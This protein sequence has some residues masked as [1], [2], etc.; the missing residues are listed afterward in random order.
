[1]TWSKE[2]DF[3]FGSVPGNVASSIVNPPF[4]GGGAELLVVFGCIDVSNSCTGAHFSAHAN[5]TTS[6]FNTITS[7]ATNG[8]TIFCMLATWNGPAQ[9][10][11][12]GVV[13]DGGNSGTNG[14]KLATAIFTGYNPS[15]LTTGTSSQF[16]TATSGTASATLVGINPGDLV[17]AMQDNSGNVVFTPGAGYSSVGTTSVWFTNHRTTTIS[18]TSLSEPG[19]TATPSSTLTSSLWTML[20]VQ[21]P[22]QGIGSPLLTGAI[23]M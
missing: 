22:G 19:P 6:P 20:A 14:G 15:I 9:S 4:Q 23:L 5:L 11:S 3:N 17:V 7:T 10:P 21:L 8:V 18:T 2:S 12:I 13:Y 1:M 16:T